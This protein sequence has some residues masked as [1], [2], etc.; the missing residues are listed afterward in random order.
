[1]QSQIGFFYF[2]K[3]KKIEDAISGKNGQQGYPK[4]IRTPDKINM[5]GGGGGGKNMS[6]DFFQ[7]SATCPFLLAFKLSAC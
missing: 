2:M 3:K 1:M 4:I 5:L 6:N 7:G